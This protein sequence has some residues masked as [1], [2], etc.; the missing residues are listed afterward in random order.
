MSDERCPAVHPTL[1]IQCERRAKDCCGLG[2]DHLV[3]LEDGRCEF[4]PNLEGRTPIQEYFQFRALARQGRN[5]Q[6][7]KRVKEIV[8]KEEKGKEEEQPLGHPPCPACSTPLDL[9][10]RDP[11]AWWRAMCKK[12]FDGDW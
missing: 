1:G 10:L 9:Q 6:A 7:S 8:E 5:A 12:W 3:T 2:V 11:R 4:W